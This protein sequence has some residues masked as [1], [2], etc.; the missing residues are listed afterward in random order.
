MA[1][2]H[3]QGVPMRTPLVN[4]SQPQDIKALEAALG[5]AERDARTL[6]SGLGE[7]IGA[8]RAG[9]GSW[10][11]AE[12]LDHLAIANRV[13]LHA[14][15]PAAERAAREG[16]RRRRPARPGLIGGWFVRSLEPP[17]KPRMKGKAPR[18]IQPRHAPPLQDAIGAFLSS[19]DEVRAF[20]RTYAEIDLVGVRFPNPFVRG[21]RFSVA[22]GLHV[23][24]AHE[25]RHLW[26]AWRVRQAAERAVAA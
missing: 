1:D 10:S 19:Q 13:Y 23:I 11:V 5:E 2:R 21:V 22:T 9:A 17:V 4:E 24:A 7:G 12:C 18:S 20:L 15:Q 6:V 25:R 26:Q 16:R 3:Q 14:M 8:W